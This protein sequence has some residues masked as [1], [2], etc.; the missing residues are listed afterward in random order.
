MTRLAKLSMLLLLA[1]APACNREPA[2]E[3]AEDEE[4]TDNQADSSKELVSACNDAMSM[5]VSGGLITEAPKGTR[6][7][8]DEEIWGMFPAEAK[9]SLV[10]C[11]KEVQPQGAL[12]PGQTIAVFG[13]KSGKKIG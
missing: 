13:A 7:V 4:Q 10:R 8:V 11:A 1:L 12:G 2:P 9:A 3:F 5:A 6:L